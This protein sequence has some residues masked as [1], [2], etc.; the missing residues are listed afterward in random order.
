MSTKPKPEEI[1]VYVQPFE[2]KVE[3][4]KEVKVESD[5]PDSVQL[6][7]EENDDLLD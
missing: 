1:E 4:V 6:K 3:K 7:K 5:A 2:A